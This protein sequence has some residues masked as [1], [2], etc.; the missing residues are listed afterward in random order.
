MEELFDI[1][2]GTGAAL[3][4]AKP[5]SEVHANGYWHR[6][7]HCWIIF[8]ASEGK[9]Y[10][11]LQKRAPDKKSWP[12]RLDISAAGHYSAGEGIEGGRK[13]DADFDRPAFLGK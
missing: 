11:L 2:D 4:I 3:N 1:Y 9:D 5:K 13:K 7:F 8:R 10:I 12:N 6:S